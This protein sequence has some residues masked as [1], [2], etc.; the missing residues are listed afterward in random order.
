MAAER[1][2]DPDARV[3]VSVVTAWE[4]VI[5]AGTGKMVLHRPITELWRDSIARNGIEVPNVTADHVFALQA[6]PPH[7]RDPFDRLLIAH[8]I[9]EGHQVVGADEMFDRYPVDRIW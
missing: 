6:L 2:A 7:H 9:S 1:I 3:I 4:I 8:A 5:K